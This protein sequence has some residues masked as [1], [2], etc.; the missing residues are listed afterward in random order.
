[1]CVLGAVGGTGCVTTLPGTAGHAPG[2]PLPASPDTSTANGVAEGLQEQCTL[3]LGSAKGFLDSWKALA[4]AA[5]PP[6]AE[7]RNGLAT[8]V[9]GY[10]DQ[11]NAQLPTMTDLGLIS[12]V[13]TI[14]AE[15]YT[16]VTGLQSG[17]AVELS[18]YS[19]AVN[20]TTEYCK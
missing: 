11:L 14:V 13:Q 1:M 10:I 19:A 2:S 5:V 4:T 12:H 15:M 6:T 18:A 20:A 7:Q 16:I 8:E 3:A 17:I 9:Q